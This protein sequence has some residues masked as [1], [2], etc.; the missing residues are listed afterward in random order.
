M[1]NITRQLLQV[2]RKALRFLH[3]GFNFDFKKPYKIWRIDGKFTLNK[4]YNITGLSFSDE[5]VILLWDEIKQLFYLV[6]LKRNQI[7]I[8]YKIYRLCNNWNLYDGLRI[9][10]F[11]RKLD[12][13]KMRKN[14]NSRIYVLYQSP[15]YKTKPKEAQKIEPNIRYDLIKYQYTYNYNETTRRIGNIEIKNK[16]NNLDSLNINIG[17]NDYWGS[18][19]FGEDKADINNIIDKSGYLVKLKRNKLKQRVSELKKER[20]KNDFLQTNHNEKTKQVNELKKLIKKE[21]LEKISATDNVDVLLKLSSLLYFKI[22][23]LFRSIDS[24]NNKIS[25]NNF[26]S[27]SEVQNMYDNIKEQSNK[28]IESLSE[29]G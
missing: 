16:N 23:S 11:Y 3:N 29:L 25:S 24:F 20:L 8:D 18:D 19:C 14:E 13:D 22:I 21:V 2:N 17:V 9:D 15:E 12:F 10:N 7:N 6:T 26:N 5:A 1:N 28:I 27:N 4:I